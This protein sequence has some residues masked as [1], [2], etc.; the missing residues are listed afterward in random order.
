MLLA[1]HAQVSEGKLFISGGCWSITGPDP[2]P[3]AVAIKI[4]VPWDRAN[5][6]YTFDLELLTEDG[7]HVMVPTPMGDRPVQLDGS[8][9]AGRPAGLKPGSPLDVAL[10]V[11]V[12]PL[13]LEPDRRYAWKLSIDGQ[14]EEDWRLTFTTRP[15]PPAPQ[16]SEQ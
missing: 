5:H 3:H 13:P 11:N 15:R 4:D 2:S 10:A 1:D 16:A 14:S 12:P 6:K 9:E 8:F 7:H